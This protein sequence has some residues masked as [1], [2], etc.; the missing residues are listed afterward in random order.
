M[1]PYS[2][3]VALGDSFTEGIGDPHPSSRNELRG[4]ADRVAPHLA[5]RNPDLRYANLTV[6]GR[7]MNDFL[8]DQIQAAV[9]LEPDLITIY[10]GMNDLLCCAPIWT[11]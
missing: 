1:V 6:R 2:R 8:V 7:T 10:A 5:Q 9:M 3:Y 4:W 11:R